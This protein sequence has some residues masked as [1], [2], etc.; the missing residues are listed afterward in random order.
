MTRVIPLLATAGLLLVGCGDPP[1]LEQY[2]FLARLGQDT[3]SVE[4][5]TRYG[6]HFV[7]E[8]VD[9]FP[10]VRRRHTEVSLAQDGSPTRM[11]MQVRTPS[12]EEKSRERRIVASFSGDSVRVSLTDG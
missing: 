10:Q 11:D 6:D 7:S 8:E 1:P 5:V 9:R 2:G 3:I 4:S 12:A